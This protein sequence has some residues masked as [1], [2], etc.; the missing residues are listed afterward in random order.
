VEKGDVSQQSL[1]AA[2]HPVFQS[3]SRLALCSLLAGA[4][5]LAPAAAEARTRTHG[6]SGDGKKV[7]LDPAR[8]FATHA[9][10]TRVYQ[11]R[12]KDLPRGKAPPPP[13]DDAAPPAGASCEVVE[14]TPKEEGSPARTRES[15]TMI[16]GR[17]ARPPTRLSYE[18]RPS[19]IFMVE[20]LTE[21]QKPAA[22]ER[23]LLPPV[24]KGKSWSEK[25]GRSTLVRTVKSAGS[26]CKAAGRSFGDCLVL[27]VVEREGKKVRKSWDETYAGGVGLVEDAQ[28]Q[29]IDVEGL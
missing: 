6:A 5:L 11:E 19:G 15:C 22:M 21:G 28:W 20:A 24:R 29:L 18:L 16:A 25:R 7:T 26:S 27:K 9:G 3:R 23:L 17:K 10:L 12:P 2:T 14:S 1:R 4:L 8:W 13:G